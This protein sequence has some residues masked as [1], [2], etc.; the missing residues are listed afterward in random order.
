MICNEKG[1]LPHSEYFFFNPD[2]NFHKYYYCVLNCGHFYCQKGYRIRRHGNTIPLFLYIIDGEFHLEYEGCHYTAGKGDILLINGLKPHSYYSGDSCDFIYI[3][4]SGGASIQLT[5]HL[6]DRNKAPLF[7][8]ADTVQ[9]YQ[10][11]LIPITKLYYREPV[12]D[13]ELSCTI[14]QCLCLL[15]ECNGGLTMHTA[16]VNPIIADSIRFIRNNLAKDLNLNIL[17]ENAGLSICYYA[18]LFKKESGFSPME[19]I[20]KCRINLAKTILKT[21][22]Q[23]IEEIAY[24]LGYSSASSFIN[25]FTSREGISP[26]KFRNSP[27]L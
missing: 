7:R 15:M 17:A 27:L 9:I 4:Y 20:S 19:Y 13:V 8:S 24:S 22:Q 12:T 2:E 5:N 25:A 1:V 3:H 16:S 18:H 23:S 26:L 21:T 10:Q 14:Y 11:A 6:I